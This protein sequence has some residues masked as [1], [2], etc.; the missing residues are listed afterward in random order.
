MSVVCQ[1][2][3]VRPA[4]VHYTE[5]VNNNIVTLNL[6][7]E[8]AEQKGIDVQ[9]AGAAG[10][11]GLGDLVAGLI[12]TTVDM[13]SDKI[14][15]VRCPSCGY[16]YSDFKKIG[17]FGC[18]DCYEAFEAQLVPML[19]QIHG[20]THHSGT[21]PENVQPRVKRRRRV[22]ELKQ[23]LARAI[24]AENYERAAEIRDEIADMESQASSD[25][26]RGKEGS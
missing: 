6:C 1:I 2:C 11:Y 19:R 20:N 25:L 10:S 24:E 4:K 15:K 18:P 3:K 22:S 17:R 9:K 16:E 14:G 26:E 13:E 7:I 12:D 23:E 21:A 5:I 8:C